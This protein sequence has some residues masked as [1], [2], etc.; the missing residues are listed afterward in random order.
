MLSQ[1]QELD[2]SQIFTADERV[3]ESFPCREKLSN[4][5]PI[6]CIKGNWE[7]EV[8]EGCPT[9]GEGEC[10]MELQLST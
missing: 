2:V 3:R 1:D 9:E 8:K 10:P 4:E 6:G 7:D 5:V